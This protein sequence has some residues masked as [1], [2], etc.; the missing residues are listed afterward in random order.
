MCDLP[1]VVK[2]T[3]TEG[4]LECNEE[5]CTMTPELSQDTEILELESQQQGDEEINQDVSTQE[6]TS[7][8]I[9]VETPAIQQEANPEVDFI[10]DMDWGE[11]EQVQSQPSGDTEILKEQLQ[12]EEDIQSQQCE[13]KEEQGV[14]TREPT[15]SQSA[16]K[17]A[18]E[19]LQKED[20]VT[21][22]PTYPGVVD[23][24]AEE[25]PEKFVVR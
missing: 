14:V 21:Q 15:S 24:V 19:E 17:I 22:E 8:K 12:T 23:V 1:R 20:A 7:L 16:P 6:P 18:K 3:I 25:S 11:D 9:V 2:S 10:P 4:T 13:E 5:I